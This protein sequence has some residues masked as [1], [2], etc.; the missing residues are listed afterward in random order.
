MR[1]GSKP[2]ILLLM[3][4]LSALTLVALATISIKIN[5]EE[6]TRDKIRA[7]QKL[8]DE[9]SRQTNLLADY[10]TAIAKE[11]IVKIASEKLGMIKDETPYTIIKINKARLDE[12]NS[13]LDKEYDQ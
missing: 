10:Q 4:F 1:K 12:L 7:E 13:I 5:Y 6:L 3:L 11:R 2:N 8:K 9:K